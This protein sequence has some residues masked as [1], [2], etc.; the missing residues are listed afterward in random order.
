MSQPSRPQARG[1]AQRRRRD[2]KI[3]AVMPLEERC[4]LAP[5][6]VDL[7]ATRGVHGGRRPPTNA[8]AGD[9]VAITA[10]QPDAGLP[11]RRAVHLGHRADPDLL[12]R[13]RHRPDPGGAGRRLRQRRLRDLPGR[14]RN[15]LPADRPENPTTTP[16]IVS[17]AINR[18]GVIYRV[19]PA[20][21]K[22]SVF[23]DLNTVVSQLEPGGQRRATRSAPRRAWSTGT[24]S[25]STPRATSTASRRCSSPASTGPTRPRTPSTGSRPTARSWASFVAVHRRAVGAEVQRQP[26]RRSWSRRP[27]TSRSSAACSPA[28]DRRQ[29]RRRRRRRSPRSSSTPTRTRPGQAISTIH[30]ADRRHRRPGLTLG[31]QRR[32]DRGEPR[33]PLAG[34]LDLHRLRHARR[35][36]AS[37]P[38]RASAACRGSTASS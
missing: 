34:L 22:T 38:S 3:E 16:P 1:P 20:T 10:G 5:V 18:P 12:V 4:L 27:R 25:R 14:G 2:L 33:L 13:R 26:Q 9:V 36:A 29:H 11:H 15:G 24:T 28:R 35:R 19:D 7:A 21:G 31:P 23:F 30:A 37:P 32:A 17:G 6:V 8:N